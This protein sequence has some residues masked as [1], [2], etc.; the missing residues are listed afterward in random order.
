ME[1][2]I[3]IIDSGSRLNGCSGGFH[4][5]R[6]PPPGPSP[7]GRKSW[8][9]TKKSGT[10]NRRMP[11]QGFTGLLKQFITPP[12]G[13]H[14]QKGHYSNGVSHACSSW[15]SRRR[16]YRRSPSSFIYIQPYPGFTAGR[17]NMSVELSPHFELKSPQK[18]PG[19]QNEKFKTLNITTFQRFQKR[20]ETCFYYTA[21]VAQKR[22]AW[23]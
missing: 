17:H 22:P 12:T 13:Q 9:S 10:F 23:R 1:T 2:A 11:G 16:E 4:S 3:L 14:P 19:N 8:A 15:F 5:N 20:H 6:P 21:A 7:H 18:I